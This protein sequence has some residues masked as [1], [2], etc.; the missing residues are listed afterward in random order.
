MYKIII[1][2][3]LYLSNQLMNLNYFGL[4]NQMEFLEISKEEIINIDLLTNNILQKF[5]GEKN[6]IKNNNLNISSEINLNI[7][8]DDTLYNLQK[9]DNIINYTIN[10]LDKDLFEKIKDKQDELNAYSN[11]FSK[12]FDEKIFSLLNNLKKFEKDNYLKIH[13]FLDYIIT[14]ELNLHNIIENFP[15]I[16]YKNKNAYLAT[17]YY[18]S[19][20]KLLNYKKLYKKKI[21]Y[22][23]ETN[24]GIL[25]NQLN[26]EKI[27]IKNEL[28]TLNEF[29]QKISKKCEDESDKEFENNLSI[30]IVVANDLIFKLN[31]IRNKYN[32]IKIILNNNGDYCSDFCEYLFNLSGFLN[33]I[34]NTINYFENKIMNNKNE[35][36]LQNDLREF[37]YFIFYIFNYDFSSSNIKTKKLAESF[38]EFFH[39]KEN[40]T[41]YLNTEDYNYKIEN[42][43][44]CQMNPYGKKYLLKNYQNYS[45]SLI[46]KKR[47]KKNNYLNE[48]LFL[49][50]KYQENCFFE[51]YKDVYKQY[52]KDILKK[53]SMK[54][55]FEKIFPYL[56]DDNFIND[57]FIE[58]FFIKIKSFNFKPIG[59]LAE[60][61]SPILNVYIKG[62]FEGEDNIK[63][64]ICA[65][66]AYIILIFHEF[67]HYIRIYI[68]K[69]TGKEE[70]RKSKEL[71]RE[72]EI[73]SYFE[74]LFFGRT[75]TS[76]NFYQAIFMLNINNYEQSHTEFSKN[77]QNFEIDYD[78][79]EKEEKYVK[80]VNNAKKFLAKLEI[81]FDDSEI[82]EKQNRFQIKSNDGN[83]YLGN[84]N[85]KTGRP[86]DLEELLKGTSFEYLLNKKI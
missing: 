62:Y 14:E 47:I 5:G 20:N 51:K 59:L 26:K 28:N 41:Q 38:E 17:Y 75:V 63:S 34:P 39:K 45:L 66:S 67:S 83:L 23:Q 36:N 27:Q 21:D 1:A 64:E 81:E 71:Y 65:S 50:F 43:T 8:N 42:N 12:K 80:D 57:D 73:G 79:K 55:L 2:K 76:I 48:Q 7:Y 70:Y 32:K 85:D 69:R 4:Y 53:K 86:V 22:S 58:E 77:F 49:F 35:N 13:D 31:Q 16:T 78:E 84:N 9:Y 19:I 40:I 30:K 68:Y 60:T 29:S 3:Q 6:L 11:Y 15:L 10:N 54:I 52:F 44:L 61:I 46:K 24:A 82:T 56:E 33:L 74:K 25:E 37:D 72:G 18:Y